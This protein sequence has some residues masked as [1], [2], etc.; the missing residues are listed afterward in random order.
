MG[1]K[2]ILNDLLKVFYGKYVI[3]GKGKKQQLIYDNLKRVYI[4][5]SNK[6]KFEQIFRGELESAEGEDLDILVIVKNNNN[7]P[8]VKTRIVHRNVRVD[9]AGRGMDLGYT[10]SKKVGEVVKHYIIMSESGL[11]KRDDFKKAIS[12]GKKI[13]EKR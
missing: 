9:V 7:L 8:K 12:K 10:V 1:L 5:G 2:T 4:I 6:Q 13:Y 3:F 11:S